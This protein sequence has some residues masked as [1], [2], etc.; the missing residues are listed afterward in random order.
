MK[1]IFAVLAGLTLCVTPGA[2]GQDAATEE[3][4]N[5]MAGR[6]E[7][8]TENQQ[9]LK[10]AIEAVSSAV[11][12]EIAEVREQSARPN[13]S[14]ATHDD[15]KR[16]ADAIKELDR[17]RIED[18]SRLQE[19][20]EKIIKVLNTPVPASSKKH[21]TTTSD[22]VEPS[23]P[24]KSEKGFEYT[25]KSGDALSS[26]VAAYRAEGIKVTMDQVLKANPG[27]KAGKVLVG[28]KIWIPAPA[29]E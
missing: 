11:S 25:V 16:L 7:E 19:Q 29:K 17:K 20:L 28:Q 14:Y 22:E 27:L 12:R 15:L 8:L 9:A 23:K 5:K 3:R 10:R 13:T 4:L 24:P 6:I 18:N 2:Q 21:P 26:I 1:R